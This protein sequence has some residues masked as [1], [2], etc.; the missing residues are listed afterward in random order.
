MNTELQQQLLTVE[1]HFIPSNKG[2]VSLTQF[3]E[4]NKM[5]ILCLPSITEE[6]NL[7]RAVVAKQAQHFAAHQ[8]PVV[9]LDYAGTGD[10]QGEFEEVTPED[11]I[12]DILVAG[13]WL[14]DHGVEKIV[15]W[16][17]RFGSLLTICHQQRLLDE[18]PIVA[19]IH[20]KPVTNGKMFAN[21]FIRIKQANRMMNADDQQKV[22]W[23]EHILAGNPTEIAGYSMT[24]EMLTGID[25]L[26][27]PTD[28][29]P[30]APFL[31]LD[32]GSTTATPAVTRFTNSWSEDDVKLVCQE[33]PAFWQVPEVFDLPELYSIGLKFLQEL[34]KQ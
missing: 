11:W 18:L 22:N 21:Q 31:W 12:E 24:A 8:I 16:G 3:G 34:D 27:V 32:L 17:V 14:L 2:N 15:I 6:L 7:A 9:T 1:G 5:T 30:Q 13:R 23:R 10:S 4:L 29:I 33:A 19:Q 25:Q 26:K 20:W 28:F